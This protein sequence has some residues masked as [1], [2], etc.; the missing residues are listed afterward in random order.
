MEDLKELAQVV[1]RNK[2]KSLRTIDS[3]ELDRITDFYHRILNQ[4]LVTDEAAAEFY[5]Q[6]DPK[7]PRYRRLKN[8]L[9][10]R[11]WNS[12]VFI[13]VNSPKFND[14]QKAHYTC[15]KN[16]TIIRVL[17]GRSAK[18]AALDL[19]KRTLK[20]SVKYEVTEVTLEFYRILRN[21]HASK[22]G[23]RK[24]FLKYSSL[25]QQYRQILESENLALDYFDSLALL[26][27]RQTSPPSSYYELAQE[28]LSTLS[29]LNI[30]SF[31]FIL[32]SKTIACNYFLHSRRYTDL[33]DQ[34]RSTYE[35]LE[36]KGHVADVFLGQ[37]IFLEYVGHVQLGDVDEIEKTFKKCI[38]LF[39]DGTARWYNTYD[40]YFIYL[41]RS[42]KYSQLINVYNRVTRQ[43]SFK[44]QT[45]KRKETWRTYRAYIYFL[46]QVNKVPISDEIDNFKIRKFL[47]DVP[48]F[49]M[50]KAG[51]NIP[52]L[53]A[54]ILILINTKKYEQIS[55]HIEAIEK[56]SSR[57]LRKEN[58]FRSNCFIKMLLQIPKR[59]YH[60]KAVE[61]HAMP[62]LKKLKSVPL[63][64][65]NQS[66]E[67]EI[68]PYE[69]LW[70]YILQ[71][72]DN[73]FH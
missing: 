9:K 61:R 14:S 45:Q 58:N 20:Y 69:H 18:S 36:G 28:A 32:F 8:R 48:T 56:Y 29:T 71:S 31:R 15:F 22:T 2:V 66:F 23:D 21:Y 62:Y 16:L 52:V 25:I 34:A 40:Q 63:N 57:Y 67:I 4:E 50:D 17:I 10:D 11:L 49:A 46:S 6:S 37:F 39:E 38:S 59:Q 35:I 73:R 55:D 27:V 64:K 13:D 47:N 26:M 19:L 68:I 24:Q 30:T 5:F 7:D 51:Y 53:V 1:N 65:A 12:V 33:I 44:Y 54:Q 41:V 72:L 60:R 42:K 3:Q 43:D 70:E